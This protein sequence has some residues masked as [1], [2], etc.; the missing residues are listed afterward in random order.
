MSSNAWR[1]PGWSRTQYFSVTGNVPGNAAPG[2]IG[3]TQSSAQSTTYF[4]DAVLL[5]DHDQELRKTEHPIQAGASIVDHAY[6]L[7]ARL[8]L[9]IGMSDAMDSL[10]SGQWTAGRTKSIAAFTVLESLQSLRIPLTVATKLKTYSNMLCTRVRAA[11]TQKTQFALRATVIFEEMIVG[12]VS[13]TS[14][15]ASE[16]PNQTG[17]TNQGTVSP[18]PVP[19]GLQ[20][21]LDQLSGAGK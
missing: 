20:P 13:S 11:D 3:P 15:N 5:S 21:Y 7:P 8:V 18:E 4:F 6:L 9:E 16:R 12:S 10:K 1:P 19:P 14:N 17:N 2:G